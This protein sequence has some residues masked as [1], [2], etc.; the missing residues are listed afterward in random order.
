MVSS[1]ESLFNKIRREKGKL[2]EEKVRF[3]LLFLCKEGKIDGFRRDKESDR[4]GI[5]FWVCVGSKNYK[6]SVKSSPG[7]VFKEIRN[8]PERVRKGDLIFIVPTSSENVEDLADRILSA[9]IDLEERM[10]KR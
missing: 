4:K 5:D 10:H 1:V 6:L 2:S 8:H 9:M 7:G 3:A